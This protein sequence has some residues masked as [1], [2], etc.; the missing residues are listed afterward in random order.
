MIKKII[1]CL[2]LCL[3]SS[4]VF[5]QAFVKG[6]GIRYDR[7]VPTVAPDTTYGTEY[8]INLLNRDIYQWDRDNNKWLLSSNLSRPVVE[9]LDTSLSFTY[10]KYY[11]N[12]SANTDITFTADTTGGKYGAY[13]IARIDFDSVSINFIG[14]AFDSVQFYNIASGD[15]LHG[16]HMIYFEHTPY[17]V[18]V[19]V[20]TNT[21]T[22]KQEESGGQSI[23]DQIGNLSIEWDGLVG[24]DITGT[25]TTWTDRKSSVAASNPTSGTQPTLN[26]SSNGLTFSGSGVSS[27]YDWLTFGASP[28]TVASSN[29]HTW[30]IAINPTVADDNFMIGYDSGASGNAYLA[31]RGAGNATYVGA[32]AT[33]PTTLTTGNQVFQLVCD[34]TN[35]SYYKDNVLIGS[36]AQNTTALTFSSIG[37]WF[38]DT[39]NQRFDGD[40]YYISLH[41]KAL[42]GTERTQ[43]FDYLNSRFSLGL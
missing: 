35:C 2:I 43:M 10:T 38:T 8:V 24:L 9:T 34:G 25:T 37:N 6:T 18:A 31:L 33:I 30:T 21:T 22:I 32:S 26:L 4:A 39:T 19:S 3:I 5:S 17:G 15:T 13:T 12:Y 42:N 28:I 23:A 27:P 41:S 29:A 14:A 1:T 11:T 40:M 16:I 36:A 20:P 7:G